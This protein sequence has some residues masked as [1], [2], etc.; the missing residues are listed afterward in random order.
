M[1]ERFEEKERQSIMPRVVQREQKR[2]DPEIVTVDE[3]NNIYVEQYN[4]V[5]A[6]YSQFLF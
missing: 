5:V 1:I 6:I 3:F 2:I 4:L